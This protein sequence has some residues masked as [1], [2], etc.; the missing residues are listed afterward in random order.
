MY[1]DLHLMK[2]PTAR[3]YSLFED[4][5]PSKTH[6]LKITL[7]N[8]YTTEQVT[9]FFRDLDAIQRFANNINSEIMN[10]R[11][12]AINQLKLEGGDTE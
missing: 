7:A 9:L 12:E 11:A 10:L 8:D 4:A 3:V 1:L 2:D 5:D 6:T